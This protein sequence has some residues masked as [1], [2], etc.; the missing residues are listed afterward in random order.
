MAK[1]EV[2]LI[3]NGDLR[4]IFSSA[5]KKS[6]KALAIRGASQAKALAPVDKSQLRNSIM[7]K[8]RNEEGG[9]N[10]KSGINAED[11]LEEQQLK[12]DEAIVGFNLLYGIY[13]EY[14]TRKMKPQPF[15]RPA[16]A[17]QKGA[18]SVEIIKKIQEEE[19]KGS[20]SKTKERVKF[21]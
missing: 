14:G 10:N 16:L 11:K 21:F 8:T 1:V 13:Q 19:L 5:T 20:L 12:D 6:L 2:E 17:L 18:D 3:R 9:F 4:K 7:W 15:L